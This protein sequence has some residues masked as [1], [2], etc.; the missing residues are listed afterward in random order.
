ME[1]EEDSPDEEQI[2][3]LE[4]IWVKAGEMGE[5]CHFTIMLFC[6]LV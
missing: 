3:V 5:Y 1:L 2:Q 4:D 6:F